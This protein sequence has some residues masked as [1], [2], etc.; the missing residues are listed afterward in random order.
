MT[1][2]CPKCGL[3]KELCVCE[4]IAKEQQKIVVEIKQKRYKK[5]ITVIHGISPKNIDIKKLLKE[6]KTELACGGTYKNNEI[7]L[8]GNHKDKILDILVK[9]GFPKESIEV[10]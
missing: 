8:Q 4:K 6:L 9:H 1:E 5:I 3:P 10:R 2:V 7:E